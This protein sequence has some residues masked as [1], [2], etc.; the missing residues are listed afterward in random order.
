MKI[1]ITGDTHMPRSAKQLPSRLIDELRVAELIIHTGDWCS[2]EVVEMLE[3]Y[4]PVKGVKGNN[5]GHDIFMRYPS[6]STV[7]ADGFRLGVVHGDGTKGS[8]ASRACAAF[9]EDNVDAIIFG[10]SHIPLHDIKNG[11]HLFNP[12]S[13]TDKRKQSRFSFGVLE[14]R[15]CAGSRILNFRHIYYDSKL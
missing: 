9:A 11:V 5:D 10:H 3:A 15:D 1:V 14:T 2:L 7:E 13:P 6:R 12:G 4:A 8:T